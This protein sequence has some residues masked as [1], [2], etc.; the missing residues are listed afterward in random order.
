MPG[1]DDITIRRYLLGQ[2]T[3]LEQQQ[4]EELLLMDETGRRQI[5]IVE[6]ELIEEYLAGELSGDELSSFESHFMAPPSRR[7]NLRVARALR[8]YIDE[9]ANAAVPAPIRRATWFAIPR[10]ALAAS[11]LVI[12]AAA[13]FGVRSRNNHV[14]TAAGPAPAPAATA[15]PQA[16]VIALTPGLLRSGG[17]E[18]VLKTRPEAASI[19]FDLQLPPDAAGFAG[20]SAALSTVEGRE[21]WRQAELRRDGN[22]VKISVP[23]SSLARGDWRIA[24]AGTTAQGKP[25]TVSS[26]YFRV[27]FD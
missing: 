16:V 19:E 25:S 9:H 7:E 4:A 27:L 8:R 24:L 11:V 20:Y 3:D 13:W 1:V 23:T 21:V 2:A 14:Q 18:P 12:A 6:D 17:A 5:A 26:Y 10:F 15:A 22:T